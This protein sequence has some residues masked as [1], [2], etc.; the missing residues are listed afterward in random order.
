MSNKIRLFLG[1]GKNINYNKYIF[2]KFLW[3][4]AIILVG[5]IIVVNI[6]YTNW[7]F[8]QSKDAKF[9]TSSP[10]DLSQISGI[11]KVRSCAGHDY[12]GENIKGEIETNRSM[13]HYA[14]PLQQFNNTK[15]QVKIF[16]PWDG[17]IAKIE[18]ASKAGSTGSSIYFKY[19]GWWFEFGH[20]EPLEN[21]KVGQKV[22][23]GQLIGYVEPSNGSAFDLQFYHSG[24]YVD[25]NK[26]IDSYINHLSAEV[27]AQY[28]KYGFNTEN[29]VITKEYRD[30]HPCQG[31]N[32]NP[33]EDFIIVQ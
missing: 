5:I 1:R 12:S 27:M 11:S 13:K 8:E 32:Q 19:D 30:Q 6:L 25:W 33:M 18:A 15:G 24:K 31:F 9:I 10:I 4:W 3:L 22:A 16:A 17:K 28:N 14:V 29:M 21:L 23:S 2:K 7:R 26:G 20:V